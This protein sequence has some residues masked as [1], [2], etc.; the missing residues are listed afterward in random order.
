MN[1]TAEH[2]LEGGNVA[3]AV[4]RVGSTVRETAGVAT[5]TFL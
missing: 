4:A 5:T 1:S 2:I 3:E